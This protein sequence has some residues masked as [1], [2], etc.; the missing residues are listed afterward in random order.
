[1][2]KRRYL[3]AMGAL[4]AAALAIAALL[5]YLHSAGAL[6]Q[7]GLTIA[8]LLTVAAAGAGALAVVAA[9][10]DS[11]T[12]PLR[13]VV[14]SLLSAASGDYEAATDVDPAGELHEL[15]EAVNSMRISLRSSTISRDYLDRLLS[16][17][18]E[19]LLIADASGR[20]ERANKAAGELFGLSETE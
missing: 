17:M 11:F 14:A 2:L 7:R 3:A 16:G 18:G 4:S 8:L 6:A 20:I 19:A 10:A 5:L 13:K 15:A 1:G 9:L 12:R